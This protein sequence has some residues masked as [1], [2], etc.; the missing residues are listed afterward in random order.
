MR[1]DVLEREMKQG[2]LDRVQAKS[3]C[4]SDAD[5]AVQPTSVPRAKLLKLNNVSVGGQ[6]CGGSQPGGGGFPPTRKATYC[7]RRRL[8]GQEAM[9]IERK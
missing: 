5:H 2:H 9:H 6:P 3:S 4:A 8:P 1:N 7:V